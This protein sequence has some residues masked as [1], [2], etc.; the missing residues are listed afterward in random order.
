MHRVKDTEPNYTTE[1]LKTLTQQIFRQQVV[2]A[3]L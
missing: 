3:E 2:K 1:E